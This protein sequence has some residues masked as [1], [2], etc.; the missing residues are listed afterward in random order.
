M[1]GDE[2]KGTLYL[3]QFHPPALAQEGEGRKHLEETC[4]TAS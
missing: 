2:T 3:T 1:G 4:P